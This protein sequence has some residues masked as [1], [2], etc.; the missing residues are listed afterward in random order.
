MSYMRIQCD[1]CGGR[2]EVYHRDDWHDDRARTCPHCYQK[3]DRQLWDRQVLPA[4]GAV[5]DLNK[6]LYKEHAG[7]HHP[8]FQIGFYPD[9]IFENRWREET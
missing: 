9:T 4:F 1:Y 5:E 6:E 7:Y 3:I 8:L 2:W